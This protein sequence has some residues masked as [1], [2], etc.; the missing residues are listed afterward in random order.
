MAKVAKEYYFREDEIHIEFLEFFQLMNQD[1]L[2]KSLMSC[3][4]L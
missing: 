4:C 3:Y 2:D 1:A